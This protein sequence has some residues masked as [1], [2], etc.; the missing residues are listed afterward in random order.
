[1]IK[2]AFSIDPMNYLD[3]VTNSCMKEREMLLP[4]SSASEDTMPN[5]GHKPRIMVG[6][7]GLRQY[8]YPA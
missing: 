8:V 5:A 7:S 3:L 6:I 4:V 1:M 2:L